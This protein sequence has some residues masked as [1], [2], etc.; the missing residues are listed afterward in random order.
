MKRRDANIILIALAAVGGGVVAYV[1]PLSLFETGLATIGLSERF[2][3]LA[4]PLGDTAQALLIGAGAL[5]CA[6]LAALFLP[7]DGSKRPEGQ[8]KG[9]AMSFIFSRLAALTRGRRRKG[10]P[11]LEH[12]LDMIVPTETPVLRRSDAHPDAP[13]RSPLFARRDL[14]EDALPP[15]DEVDQDVEAAEWEEVVE[16]PQAAQPAWEDERELPVPRAPEPLPWNLIEQEM[17]RIL[18]GEAREQ[19]H[20]MT[21]EGPH[22]GD[23]DPSIPVPPPST[24]QAG[25]MQADEP[26][27]QGPAV[28]DRPSIPQLVDRLEQGLRR[29][30]AQADILRQADAAAASVAASAIVEPQGATPESHS[31]AAQFPATG[32]ADEAASLS[33]EDLQRALA[34]LRANGGGKS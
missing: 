25:A 13:A 3:A 2:P 4:P 31:P 22:A 29:K 15:V 19:P 1:L 20:D 12:R 18:G 9:S 5:V 32:Q 33:D 26:A 7:W 14:G 10:P 11:S 16:P 21:D 6:L 30:R 17:S 28:D 23:S 8:Q 34:A 27:A 24:M